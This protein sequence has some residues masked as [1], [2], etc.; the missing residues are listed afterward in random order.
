MVG[1]WRERF[2]RHRVDGLLD[3]PRCGAPRTVQDDKVD[4][5]IVRTLESTP[6]RPRTGRRARWPKPA[7]SVT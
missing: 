7:D 4:A 2:V 6:R 5:V 3:E 1:K